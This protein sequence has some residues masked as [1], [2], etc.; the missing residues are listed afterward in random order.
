M[1]S[2]MAQKR[3]VRRAVICALLG[4]LWMK[5]TVG[6][7]RITSPRLTNCRKP[8]H[9]QVPRKPDVMML[10]GLFTPAPKLKSL[11]LQREAA[12]A[13]HVHH[14]STELSSTTMAPAVPILLRLQLNKV[15]IDEGSSTAWLR[16]ESTSFS[17][18]SSSQGKRKWLPKRKKP[19]LHDS[20][21]V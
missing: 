1:V 6:E 21:T 7:P 11:R 15:P 19:G 14:V 8:V 12:T 10:L 9:D 4:Q 5:G 2:S 13:R 17:T 16:Q 3:L 18:F 20:E